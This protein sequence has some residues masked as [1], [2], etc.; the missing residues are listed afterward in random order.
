MARVLEHDRLYRIP[1]SA[2]IV[3]PRIAKGARSRYSFDERPVYIYVG[4]PGDL[5]DILADMRIDTA[6]NKI[7]AAR[8]VA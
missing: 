2:W 3:K 7:P 4:Q 6:G 5:R 8:K 1:G